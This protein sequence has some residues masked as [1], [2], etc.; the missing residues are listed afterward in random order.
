MPIT[1]AKRAKFLAAST[2]ALFLLISESMSASV[3]YT[4]DELGRVRTALYD[5]GLCV[6]YAY[7]ANGNRTSQSN[8]ISTAA[9]TPYWGAGVWGCFPW[10]AP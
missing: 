5:N 4:Y 1:T 6:A 3:S 10:T 8:T 7:D 2:L 9:E